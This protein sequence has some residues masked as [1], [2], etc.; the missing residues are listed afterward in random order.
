MTKVVISQS[1]WRVEIRLKGHAGYNPGNDIVCSAI[2]NTCYMLLNFLLQED[3]RTVESF[4]DDPGD[5]RLDINPL[6]SKDEK[7]IKTAIKMFRIGIDQ[8]AMNY[9]KHCRLEV[10]NDAF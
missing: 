10:K 2:S 3:P 4:K 8:I 7:D 9:P 5:F 6:V 1:P